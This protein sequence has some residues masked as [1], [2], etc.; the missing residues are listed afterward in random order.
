[1]KKRSLLLLS[2]L[3]AYGRGLICVVASKRA[4]PQCPWAPAVRTLTML[5]YLASPVKRK[6]AAEVS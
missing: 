3:L 6:N 1:L 2:Y 4:S 5:A